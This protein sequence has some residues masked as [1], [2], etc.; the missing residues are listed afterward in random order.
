MIIAG[1]ALLALGYTLLAIAALT[2]IGH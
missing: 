2:G 1:Y